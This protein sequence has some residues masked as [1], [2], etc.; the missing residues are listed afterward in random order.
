MHRGRQIWHC[1]V[2]STTVGYGDVSLTTDGSML[3]ASFHILVSV[4]WLASLLGLIS[5]TRTQR[6]HDLQRAD[7]L[8]VQ[9]S[10][11]LI[12]TLDRDGKGVEELEFVVG[13]II[14]LGAVS[15]RT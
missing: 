2:T 7:A 1:W 4:S 3:W 10:E 5:D 9:L 12:K 6:T 11:D 14:A 8:A 15:T 13:M